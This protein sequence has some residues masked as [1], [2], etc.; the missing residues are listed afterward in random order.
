MMQWRWKRGEPVLTVAGDANA[1]KVTTPMD[2]RIARALFG[3]S[4]A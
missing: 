4:T 3:D 2:L 1:F